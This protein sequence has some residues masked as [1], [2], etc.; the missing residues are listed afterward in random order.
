MEVS[1]RKDKD[2]AID[3]NDC[4]IVVYH[5]NRKKPAIGHGLLKKFGS[6]VIGCVV[7]TGG[8]SPYLKLER[9]TSG[10]LDG[11][12]DCTWSKTKTLH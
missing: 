10:M 2:R 5:V 1:R 6:S 7:R 11:L 8:S 12:N 3:K 4:V 9:L